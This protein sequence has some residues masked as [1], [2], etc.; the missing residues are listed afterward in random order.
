MDAETY[1]EYYFEAIFC[2][3]K[4]EQSKGKVAD[5]RPNILMLDLSPSDYVL[6]AV[7]SV[8]TNDLEQALLVSLVDMA[9]VCELLYVK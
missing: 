2:D 9:S 3:F 4:E 8:H 5:F 7:S 6:R 1:S